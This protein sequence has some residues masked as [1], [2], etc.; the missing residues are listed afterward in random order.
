MLLRVGL[1]PL[2]KMNSWIGRQTMSI[3]RSKLQ[4]SGSW[5]LHITCQWL[6]VIRNRHDP[7]AEGTLRLNAIFFL[8]FGTSSVTVNKVDEYVDLILVLCRFF[9]IFLGWISLKRKSYFWNV[10]TLLSEP[11]AW[12]CLVYLSL[13]FFSPLFLSML[14]ICEGRSINGAIWRLI[15]R[16]VIFFLT[17]ADTCL[18]RCF[19]NTE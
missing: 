3:C 11:C 6:D 1:N 2:R 8:I 10:L 4:G 17:R 9:G 13:S 12:M 18:R 14:I 5:E 16:H 19:L 7:E 15:N